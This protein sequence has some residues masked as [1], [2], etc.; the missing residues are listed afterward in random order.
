LLT[1]YFDA[2]GRSDSVGGYDLYVATRTE[3]GSPFGNIVPI[4]GAR[5]NSMKNELDPSVSGDGVTLVFGTSKLDSTMARLEYAKKPLPSVQFTGVGPALD[6]GDGGAYDDA[7]PFL[8]E[9]GQVLYFSSIRVPENGSDIYR[10]HWTGA[11]FGVAEPVGDI[12]SSSSEDY[13]V[14]SPNDLTIYFASDRLG[15]FDIWV[16]TRDSL[17]HPFTGL[18]VVNELN[19]TKADFPSFVS[20]DGCTVYFTSARS[21]YL[22][23]YVATKSAR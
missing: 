18:R 8:R 9:D 20:S 11:G 23:P 5:I 1:A 17:L 19:S 21:G 16:A 12:N 4:P 14:V 6:S 3:Y 10:A 15:D 22:A 7:T 2:D 13:P